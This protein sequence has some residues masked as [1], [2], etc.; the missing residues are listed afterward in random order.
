MKIV[1]VKF[2][3]PVPSDVFTIFSML[4]IMKF[5][6]DLVALPRDSLKAFLIMLLVSEIMPSFSFKNLMNPNLLLDLVPKVSNKAVTQTKPRPV[7]SR[8]PTDM[9]NVEFARDLN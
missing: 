8:S 9:K 1:T 5:S 4:S 7:V 6:M 3:T 2:T